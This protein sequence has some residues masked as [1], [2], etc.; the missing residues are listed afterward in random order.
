MMFD[1]DK[2]RILAE[3]AAEKNLA[4]VTLTE[5]ENTLTI[6][7]PTAFPSPVTQ[8]AP[9]PMQGYAPAPL[10]SMAPPALV[11]AVSE[12]ASSSTPVVQEGTLITAPMVGTFYAAPSPDKPSYVQVGDSITVGKTLC[13][14]EA[15]KQMNEL[16]AELSGTVLEV[17]AQNGQPVEFGQPLFRVKPL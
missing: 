14:I 6:K 8:V 15:M 1:I 11:T 12:V 5:G 13:I 9:A 7:L 10:P 4:E 2:I 16:E 17:I 3:L